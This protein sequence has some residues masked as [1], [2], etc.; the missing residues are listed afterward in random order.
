MS[1]PQQTNVYA[2]ANSP[3]LIAKA[4]FVAIPVHCGDSSWHTAGILNIP[5]AASLP[6]PAVLILHGS[7]GVDSRGAHYAD[8]F[9][10]AGL[11]TLE[12][13]LWAPRGVQ[14]SGGRPQHVRETLP[15]AF[16]A[17]HLLARMNGIIDADRI[18]VTG[19]SWG[20]IVSMLSATQANRDAFAIGAERFA[21]HAPFYPV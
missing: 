5:Y 10:R 19:F 7:G 8:A 2:R 6:C 3:R 4:S 13:D 18:G 21:A 16:A 17:L 12:L 15:D 9:N 11:A 14:G 20:G 1:E